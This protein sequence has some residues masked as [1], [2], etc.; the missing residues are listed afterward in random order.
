MRLIMVALIGTILVLSL[1]SFPVYAHEAP[2]GNPRVELVE[3][4][5]NEIMGVEGIIERADPQLRSGPEPPW[6]WMAVSAYDSEDLQC[7]GTETRIVRAGWMK[8]AF[9]GLGVYL[10]AAWVGDDGRMGLKQADEIFTHRRYRVEKTGL[11][12]NPQYWIMQSADLNGFFATYAA[13]A[14]P[15]GPTAPLDCA[16]IGGW[17]R[18]FD[19]AIGVSAVREAVIIRKTGA[20]EFWPRNPEH[21]VRNDPYQYVDL[22]PFGIDG[23]QFYG[24]N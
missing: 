6:S 4:R 11:T 5:V 14:D 15:P 3:R 2:D 17:A 7:H 1:A 21:A 20:N 13:T 12:G 19:D 9:W 24:N 16:S 10:M 22:H 18:K 8:Y 23:W